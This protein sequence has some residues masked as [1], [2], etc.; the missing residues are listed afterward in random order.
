MATGEEEGAAVGADLRQGDILRLNP[1][2]PAGAGVG[3]GPEEVHLVLVMSQT[4]D[5]MQASKEFCLVAPILRDPSA[6]DTTSALTGKKPLLVH[7][8]DG[9]QSGPWVAD[10]G[11]AF[12]L[13]KSQLASASRVA[14]IVQ[15]ASSSQAR[16]LGARIGRAY[17]RFPFPDEVQPVFAGVQS[18]LRGKAGK[19]GNL[20]KVIDLLED[21]RVS[22]DQWELP[23]RNLRLVLIVSGEVL[24]P[25]EDIDPAWTWQRI[26]GIRADDV[27]GEL[28][29]DRVCELLLVNLERDDLSSVECLWTQF[30]ISLYRKLIAPRLNVEVVSVEVEVVSDEEFTFR[31]YRESESLDL[32]TI[33]DS[34]TA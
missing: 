28:A 29:I 15:F 18:Q 11:R 31:D 3:L 12:S 19:A 27:P 32:E 34:S 7:L 6:G 24:I 13:P 16:I 20:S 10:L 9:S 33:S 14:R 17:S 25:L 22:A 21:I 2:G 1:I 26:C 5:A 8:H 30:G 4:C 23:C